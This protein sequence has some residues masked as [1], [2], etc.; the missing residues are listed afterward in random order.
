MSTSASSNPNDITPPPAGD[1]LQAENYIR[2]LIHLVDKDIVEIA[3]TDL[4]QFAVGSLQNHYRVV[5]NDYH[6]EISHS[7]HPQSGNSSYIMLFTNIRNYPQTGQKII[8]AYMHIHDIQF[9]DIK[10]SAD[11]QVA[12]VKKRAE[13]KRLKDAL[14]PIDQILDEI[15]VVE[16]T[17]P[18]IS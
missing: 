1:A 3:R 13:E 10:A 4:S 15:S 2:K 17:T 7:T 18:A 8:L 9:K 5:L 11:Q 12:R 6:V 16:I 14:K